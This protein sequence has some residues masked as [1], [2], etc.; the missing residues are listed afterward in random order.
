MTVPSCD[1]TE[2]P[3]MGQADF[4]KEIINGFTI[5]RSSS[6]SIVLRKRGFRKMVGTKVTKI[7]IIENYLLVEQTVPNDLN[8]NYFIIDHVKED[9]TGPYSYEEFQSKLQELNLP[10]ET[11]LE[12]L[13]EV[14]KK[15]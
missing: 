9:Q 11:E 14:L 15:L 1:K 8:K 7:S 5:Y 4:R 10:K 6:E 12:P 3:G 2:M 13:I